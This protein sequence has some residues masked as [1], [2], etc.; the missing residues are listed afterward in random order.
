MGYRSQW[1]YLPPHQPQ[2]VTTVKDSAG[3][4]I[5]G[6]S[7][8]PNGSLYFGAYGSLY[9]GAYGYWGWGK[10][11]YTVTAKWG[12]GPAP[13]SAVE[14]VL[15]LAVNIW[16]ERDKGMFSDVVGVE[17]SGSIAVGY[18]RAFTNRQKRI[19][20]NVKRKYVSLVA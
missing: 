2:S 5:A 12:V 9:Y 4:T 20:D 18:A 19:L 13:N 8:E 14:V 16:R 1:L 11:R 6:W 10:D 15:E 3:A 17:G 7:E